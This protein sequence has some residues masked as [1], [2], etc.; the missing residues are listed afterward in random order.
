MLEQQ[1]RQSQDT[2]LSTIETALDAGSLDVSGFSASLS[3][4]IEENT[5]V[6]GTVLQ[7]ESGDGSSGLSEF[8]NSAFIVTKLLEQTGSGTRDVV[9]LSS[10]LV[11][12]H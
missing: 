3:S 6:F 1:L 12:C 5:A 2:L 11:R 9:D 7:A 8:G 10:R 4:V